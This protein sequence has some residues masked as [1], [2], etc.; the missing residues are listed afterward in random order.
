MQARLRRRCGIARAALSAAM[1]IAACAAQAEADYRPIPAA[2]FRTALPPD[3]RDGPARVAAFAMRSLPVSNA[4]FLA[5][6]MAHP[7]WQRGEAPALFADAGY[8]RHWAAPAD[9]GA[10][11]RG[12][13][14]VTWVSWFAAEAYCESEGARLPSWHEW[15]LVAAADETRRDARDDAAWR[16]RM[17]AWYSR[18]STGRLP[19]IGKT[20]RNAYGVMD[21]HGVVWEWVDDFAGIMVS[22]DNRE[23]GDPNLLKFCGAGAIAVQDRENYAVLMHLALLSSLKANYTTA[24]L[25][26]RCVRPAAAA[27]IRSNTP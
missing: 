9:L 1:L 22:A 19:S 2:Q 14:P 6:V 27:T 16:E 7:Q 20:P 23:Q 13:Q 4:E 5:F 11:V 17:L 15:E 25:G 21:L 8:L 24:N 26:F 18:P 12:D 3:G 10:E